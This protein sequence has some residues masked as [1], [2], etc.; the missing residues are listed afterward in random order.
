MMAQ[1]H[2]LVHC[3]FTSCFWFRALE[4]MDLVWVVLRSSHKLFVTY[5]G[6]E[7]GMR[8]RIWWTV[9]VHCI[10]WS[11]CLEMNKKIFD[12]L[13]KSVEEYCD[14]IKIQASSWIEKHTEFKN[15]SISYLFRDLSYI[16]CSYDQGFCFPFTY[17]DHLSTL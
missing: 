16:C 2:I 17:A 1:N 7:V 4:E 8:G 15:F 12:N 10:C 9:V 6:R 13:E 14:K 5:L 3:F 11:V